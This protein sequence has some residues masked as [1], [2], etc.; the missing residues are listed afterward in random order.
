MDQAVVSGIGNVYR[1]EILFRHALDPYRPA[2]SLSEE[3]VVAL[4]KDWA[5]LLA[6]GVKTGVMLTRNDLDA[7]GRDASSAGGEGPILC[8]QTRRSAV[9]GVRH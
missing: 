4:W 2:A 8:L 1:A 3:T 9:S 5:K 6:D 7:T